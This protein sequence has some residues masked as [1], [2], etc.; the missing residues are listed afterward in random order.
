LFSSV[1]VS[2]QVGMGGVSP[3]FVVVSIHNV[4]NTCADK[5]PQMRANL[6]ESLEKM[7]QANLAIYSRKMWLKLSAGD[8]RI[9]PTPVSEGDCVQLARELPT[10]DWKMIAEWHEI[11]CQDYMRTIAF[12]SRSAIGIQIEESAKGVRITKVTDGGPA[13]IAGLLVG[14]VIKEVGDTATPTLCQTVFAIAEA[15]S[16]IDVDLIVVRDESEKL[17]RLVPIAIPADR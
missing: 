14:D 7:I 17:I 13:S 15:K 5:Y 4:R 1:E 2:A 3:E 6:D 8:F 9:S 11:S 10:F 12:K 16:G